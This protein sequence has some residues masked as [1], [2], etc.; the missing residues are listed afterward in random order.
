[1]SCP[2][3]VLGQQIYAGIF[4]LEFQDGGLAMRVLL[5]QPLHEGS[6]RRDPLAILQF[7]ARAVSKWWIRIQ[8][9]VR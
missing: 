9:A 3:H 6:V 8:I 2:P 4:P 7:S 5:L 1:M